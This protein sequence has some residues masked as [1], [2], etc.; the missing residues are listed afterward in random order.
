MD[1]PLSGQCEAD[2]QWGNAFL[3]L[4]GTMIFVVQLLR[5]S[6]RFDVTAVEHYQVSYLICWGFCSGRVGIAAHSF[7]GF[8]EPFSEFVMYG[9]HPV[10]VYLARWVEGLGRRWAHGYWVKAIV[11]IEWR[12]TISRCASAKNLILTGATGASE[13]YGSTG[14]KI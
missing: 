14:S 3:D 12:H 8:L 2:G 5:W 13:A 6:A 1:L 10:G 9:V 11:S 7:L 4:E